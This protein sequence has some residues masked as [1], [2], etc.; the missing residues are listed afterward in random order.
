MKKK[1]TGKINKNT[2][3]QRHTWLPLLDLDNKKSRYC[4]RQPKTPSHIQAMK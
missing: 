1:R 3:F 2:Q 4:V